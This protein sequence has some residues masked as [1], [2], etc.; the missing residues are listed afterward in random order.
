MECTNTPTDVVEKQL[1]IYKFVPFCVSS[2]CLPFVNHRFVNDMASIHFR[3]DDHVPLVVLVGEEG[4]VRI[5]ANLI[6][7]RFGIC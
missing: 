1:S 2:L 3:V 6:S 4:Y 5:P 7:M